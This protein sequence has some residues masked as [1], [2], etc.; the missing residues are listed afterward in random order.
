MSVRKYVYR[1]LY[2]VFA[3]MIA[4]LRLGNE[5]ALFRNEEVY[6]FGGFYGGDF[7][8]ANAAVISIDRGFLYLVVHSSKTEKYSTKQHVIS[9][10]VKNSEI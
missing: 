3:T 5:A 10:V 6:L 1:L 7:V 4:L 2:E 9:K 8:S